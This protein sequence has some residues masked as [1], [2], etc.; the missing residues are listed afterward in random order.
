MSEWAYLCVPCS[1]SYAMRISLQ[2]GYNSRC[3]QSG[4][5][6][7]TVYQR[8]HVSY[9]YTT[10][11]VNC[12]VVSWW[13]LLRTHCTEYTWLQL[14]SDDQ[15]ITVWDLAKLAETPKQEQASQCLLTQ[16]DDCVAEC[17]TFDDCAAVLQSVRQMMKARPKHF[18][19][20]QPICTTA[21]HLLSSC[22]RRVQCRQSQRLTS[23]DPLCPRRAHARG[24]DR[25]RA[26]R[27]S[28]QLLPERVEYFT[29]W[30][31]LCFSVDEML[32]KNGYSNL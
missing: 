17:K 22:C 5:A 21:A 4:T 1:A 27:V 9:K 20:V 2:S 23:M 7:Y 24:L 13:L 3:I 28:S 18:E 6:A 25:P 8:E 11:Y 16:L 14:G 30:F 12:W 29:R 31:V 15:K 19:P 10:T 26:P 32:C